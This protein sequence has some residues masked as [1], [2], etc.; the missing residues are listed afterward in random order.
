[1]YEMF[2]RGFRFLNPRLGKSDPLKFYMEDHQVRVPL[3][4][5]SG[6]G[7]A[8]ARTLQ[9]EYERKPYTT[10]EDIRNRGKANNTAV[11]GLKELGVLD[12]IPES[13]QISLFDLG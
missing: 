3:A 13:D 7:E 12:G 9:E 11:S 10:V 8:A 2:S 6:L 4:A 1:M 5:I